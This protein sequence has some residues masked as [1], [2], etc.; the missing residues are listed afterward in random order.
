MKKF[1]AISFLFFSAQGVFSQGIEFEH[2]SWSEIVKKAKELNK[3]I[4]VDVY[5]SWCG[6]CKVMAAKVFPRPEIGA[7]Y[8]Q[9]F[10]N[11]KIDA[12]KGEGIAIAKRYE[13]ISYPTYLFINPFDE[14]LI[15]RSK[16]SMAAA[17]FNDLA[18]KMLMKFSGK[19]EESIAELD[20]KFRVGNYDE[21]FAQ[22]YI[23][24]LKAEGKSTIEVLEKYISKFLTNSPSTDQFYF[25]GLNFTKGADPGVYSYVV[26]NYKAID[27]VLC[28]TDGI[29]AA[30]LYR[31]LREETIS[32]IENTISSKQLIAEK[33]AQ[34]NQ[35]FTNLNAVEID[36]R[37]NK[38]VLEFKIRFYNSNADTL[39]LL[40]AYRAYINQFLLAS[41]KTASI[42]REAIILDKN[43]SVPV[44]PIDSTSAA[45]WCSGYAVTLS[46]LSKEA[47]DKELAA[48]LLKKA[49]EL[50]NSF[51]VKNSM[52]IVTYN[53]GEKEA[54]I[55]QQS[56][57]MAE[58]KT[59]NDEYL[60]D[61]ETTMQKMKNNDAK[62]S[63]FSSRR[64]VAKKQ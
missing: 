37:K 22:A 44:L 34:L 30:S 17:D 56:K 35:L 1:L 15:D 20:A 42:G 41:D 19:K 28:K 31:V 63:I 51:V 18:D 7:R 32:K 60:N 59:N 57:L 54:A 5:T 39:Q 38:K 24:R 61:A 4:F 49:L 10:V 6:P 27:A 2:A 16:S 55:E 14:S 52:N 58:M 29:A 11:A 53:F 43:A 40:Q 21:A 12:E 62:I 64:R 36:E 45:D 33:E 8:N 13:V 3:P 23:K 50:N 48:S 46:K 26:N 9:G 25:I 47:K